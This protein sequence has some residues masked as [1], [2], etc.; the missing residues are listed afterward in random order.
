MRRFKTYEEAQ[1]AGFT[2][3][4]RSTDRDISGPGSY[5]YKYMDADGNKTVTVNLTEERNISGGVG[6]YTPM[7]PPT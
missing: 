6:C 2:R 1:A 3:V 4:D 5:G 7:Y